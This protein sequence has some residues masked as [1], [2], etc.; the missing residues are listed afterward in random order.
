MRSLSLSDF[1]AQEQGSSEIRFQNSV[2]IALRKLSEVL[3][4][5]E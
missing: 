4:P 5:A 3:D 1:D 2:E